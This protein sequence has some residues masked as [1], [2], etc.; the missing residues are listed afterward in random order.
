MIYF[1]IEQ[2]WLNKIGKTGEI[3]TLWI[4]AYKGIR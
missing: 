1:Y 3:L 4:E 2:P